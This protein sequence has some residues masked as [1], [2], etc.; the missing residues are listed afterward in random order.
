[1]A[2]GK[3]WDFAFEDV[4]DSAPSE[5]MFSEAVARYPDYKANARE[6]LEASHAAAEA[7]RRSD[8]RNLG[9]KS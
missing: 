6:V 5:R 4:V 8:G 2:R 9:A 7:R 1:M 3:I